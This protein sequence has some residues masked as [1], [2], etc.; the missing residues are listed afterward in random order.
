MHF[1]LDKKARFRFIEDEEMKMHTTTTSATSAKTGRKAT[2]KPA[3]KRARKT[4]A[5][6]PATYAQLR[7][8]DAVAL[9]L[10]VEPCPPDQL[11]IFEATLNERHYLK[12]PRP[13]GNYLR[14]VVRTSAGGALALLEWGPACYALKDRDQ[15]IGWNANQRIE[16]LKLIVQNRRFLL[17]ADKGIAPNLAS[18][19]LAAALRAL[20]AQW[21]QTHGYRPLMAETFTDPERY[22]GTCYKAANWQPVGMSAGHSRHRAD[23]YIPNESPKHLW[24]YP[25]RPDAKK[26]LCSAELPKT[27]A[28]GRGAA[29]TGT[30]PLR[31]K[32]MDSL[33]ETLRQVP[34]PRARNSRYK[35]GA[36]LTIVCMALMAGRRDIAEITRFGQSLHHKQRQSLGLPRRPGAKLFWEAPG[37]NV[38]YHLL[39]DIDHDALAACLNAWHARH[40]GELPATLAMDGKMIREHIGT[41][42]LASH[43]DKAPWATAVYDQK[44]G[45]QRCELKAAQSL[46][47]TLGQMEGKVI[48]ADAP[49]C[50]KETASLIVERGGDYLLQIKGNQ[51]HLENLSRAR[52]EQTPG[53]P[54]F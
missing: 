29:P 4:S 41:L 3:A 27:S 6:T 53:A 47:K 54:F 39:R 51:P 15:H 38:Y 18:K 1:F 24:L 31:A 23:F 44:E 48:T 12:A 11:K 9:H 21:Q 5:S 30:L 36:V 50:Q 40:A 46:L 28:P 22:E 19:T 32:H 42:T 7:V 52:A 45:T 13:V 2:T 37:Y 25:L 35:I 43:E 49:R 20:P 16:K 26:L 10:R 8:S 33:H 34:D 17:L 14:Q